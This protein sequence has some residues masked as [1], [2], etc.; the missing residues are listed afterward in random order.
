FIKLKN[1]QDQSMRYLPLLYRKGF[2]FSELRDLDKGTRWDSLILLKSYF[3]KVHEPLAEKKFK[4]QFAL[5]SPV[6]SGVDRWEFQK[7]SHEKFSLKIQ[8]LSARTLF[9][10]SGF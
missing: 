3:S 9:W 5:D 6:F 1:P 2:V 10:S 4:E 7:Y 8:N